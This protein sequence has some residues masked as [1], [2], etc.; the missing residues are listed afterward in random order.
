[1]ANLKPID[2]SAD[3]LESEVLNIDHLEEY[4][5][6]AEASSNGNS[7]TLDALTEVIHLYESKRESMLDTF[8]QDTSDYAAL[9]TAMDECALNDGKVNNVGRN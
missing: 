8:K 5:L 2:I 1:M 3:D 6:A 4:A 7:T 9:Q